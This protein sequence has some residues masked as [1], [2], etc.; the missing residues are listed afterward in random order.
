LL[1]ESQFGSKFHSKIPIPGRILRQNPTET[2]R[3]SPDFSINAGTKLHHLGAQPHP[4]RTHLMQN[5]AK[6][7]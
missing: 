5:A 7:R 1:S 2:P 4:S 3:V 6:I